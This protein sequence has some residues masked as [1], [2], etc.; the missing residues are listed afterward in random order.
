MATLTYNNMSWEVD[1]AVLGKNYVHGYD[2]AGNIVIA[3][4]DTTDLDNIVYDGEYMQ[5]DACLEESCNDVKYLNG[6]FVTPDGK[7]VGGKPFKLAT[8]IVNDGA[9][10]GSTINFSTNVARGILDSDAKYAL[11]AFHLSDTDTTK[12]NA[13]VEIYGTTIV[14]FCNGVDGSIYSRK[15]SMHSSYIT[16]DDAYKNKVVNNKVLI[17]DRVLILSHSEADVGWLYQVTL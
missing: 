11:I 2:A 14:S 16:F 1:H 7:E 6:L 3:I 4:D 10:A 8:S 13:I 15:V 17:P 5:P 9:F 12:I